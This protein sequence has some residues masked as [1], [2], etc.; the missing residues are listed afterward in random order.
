MGSLSQC[1]GPS[2][3][4]APRLPESDPALPAPPVRPARS[5]DTERS[6]RPQRSTRPADT[7]R[8]TSPPA[9]R[10]ARRR[11]GAK[12]R[13]RDPRRGPDPQPPLPRPTASGRGQ[14]PRRRTCSAH[15]TPA[16]P[17][18]TTTNGPS[19]RA[20]AMLS[21]GRRLPVTGDPRASVP[22]EGKLSAQ[23]LPAPGAWTLDYG[24]P[25]ASHLVRLSISGASDSS[26][27][28]PPF[29][30]PVLPA[31]FSV[32]GTLLPSGASERPSL[33]V[34]WAESTTLPGSSPSRSLCGPHTI[35]LP[36]GS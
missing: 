9:R 5:R 15:V 24:C 29:P 31:S 23:S 34:L 19:D 26:G 6:T 2:R 32:C 33:L 10:P 21:G 20:A 28:A 11:G 8:S 18:P 27:V 3:V 7:E 12:G 1:Q 13:K 22:P 14:S 16:M 35:G 25:E 30:A 4:C 36:A 17:P